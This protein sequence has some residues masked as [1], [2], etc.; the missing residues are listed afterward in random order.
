MRFFSIALV[1]MITLN[2]IYTTMA[3][4]LTEL[5]QIDNLLERRTEI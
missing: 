5:S 3:I 1:S 4:P 2:S